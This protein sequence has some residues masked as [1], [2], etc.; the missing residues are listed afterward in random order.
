L[1]RVFAHRPE[2]TR[3]AAIRD[4]HERERVAGFVTF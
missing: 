1:G 4:D 3:V 2:W